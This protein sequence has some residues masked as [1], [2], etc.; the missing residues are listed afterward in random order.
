MSA[1]PRSPS[2]FPRRLVLL[3]TGLFLPAL[4]LVPGAGAATVQVAPAQQEVAAAAPAGALAFRLERLDGASRYATAARVSRRFFPAGAP[5]A[6]VVTG[7]SYPSGLA[8]GPSGARLNGP[9]LVTKADILPSATK[10]E[11]TRLRPGRIIVVGSTSA[12]SDTVRTQL[13]SYTAGTVTRVSGGDRYATAAALSAHAFPSG[14]AIAYVATGESFADGLAGG[15]AAAVQSAPML[16]TQ[17]TTLPAST[18]AELERLRPGRIMLVGN[19]T[20]VSSAVAT[21][22]GTIALVERVAGTDAHQTALALS[23]RVFGTDRPGASLA[24]ARS[25]HD[26]LTSAATARYTRGPLLLT[27]GTGLA[28]GTPKEL[29]RLSPRRAYVLGGNDAQNPT[30]PRLVQ[31]T[32]GVCW[33]GGRP[34]AGS[35]EVWHTVP[36]AGRQVAFTLD[37]G[38]RL[39]PALDIVGYLAGNQVCTTFFLTGASAD[40]A[41]GRAVIARI[42]ASPHLFEIA[43]HTYHHCDLVNGGGGSP[44]STPCKVSMTRSFIQ[45]EMTSTEKR[46]V[47]LMKG[48]PLRPYWRPPYGTHNA[49]V[50]DAVASVGYTKTVHWNRD[51]IDWST[52]TTTSQIVSRTTSPLPPNGTIVLAHL[53]GYRTLDAL[54]QIVSILRSNGYTMTTVSDMRDG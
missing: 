50:R 34:A 13:R 53:G 46:L 6:L 43:N 44:S 25:W 52:S 40:S 51:T 48:W 39:D 18:R 29:T 8:A 27:T 33:A 12:V 20:S 24:T 26:S 42:A 36:G 30:V 17:R 47:P 54:P 2:R 37:M 45:N 9:V 35:Q 4:L 41:E 7:R 31:R 38:G 10:K 28:S 16:L 22:L 14:A 5:V 15:S 11:L 1:A 3:L 19:T 49:S 32:L 23:R 21:E